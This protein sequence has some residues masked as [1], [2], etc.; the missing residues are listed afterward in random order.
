MA[1]F[2]RSTTGGT[3]M[4]GATTWETAGTEKECGRESDDGS[5]DA[6]QGGNQLDNFQAGNV[7]KSDCTLVFNK[8]IGGLAGVTGGHQVKIF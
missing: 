1:E 8:G 2:P 5:G 3:R 6:G 7:P 4:G